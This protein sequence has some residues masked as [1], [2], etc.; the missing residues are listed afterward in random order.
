MKIISGKEIN[1]RNYLS[2]FYY[3]HIFP[4]RRNGIKIRPLV[5]PKIF[6]LSYITM[7]QQEH[8]TN[9][10]LFCSDQATQES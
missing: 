5:V 1:S 4:N 3:G 10:F 6:C 2:L 8:M 7:Y 9:G